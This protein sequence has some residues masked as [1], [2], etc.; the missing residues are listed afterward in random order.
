MSQ[1]DFVVP[2]RSEQRFTVLEAVSTNNQFG[3][4][5]IPQHPYMAPN[6]FGS[7]HQDSWCSES[8]SLAGPTSTQLSLTLQRNPYGYT[9]NMVTNSANQMIG[10]SLQYASRKFF[11]VMFDQE[12]NIISATEA[13]AKQG[14]TFGGGYFYLDNHDNTVTVQ[15]NKIASYPTQEQPLK[16]DIYPLTPNWTSV[17]IVELVTGDN[18]NTLYSALPVWTGKPNLYWCLIAGQYDYNNY[19][20][21]KLESPAYMAVVEILPDGNGGSVTSLLG[22]LELENQWN[23]N[24]FAVDEQ[25]AYIVTN[26]L[27]KSG[28]AGPSYLWAFAFDERSG[29]VSVRW[30]TEYE[31]AGYLKPG[32]KNIGSGTTPTLTKAEDGTD[33]VAITDNADPQLNVLVCRRDNGQPIAQVPCFEKMRSADEA[34]LIGVGSTFVAE[35]NFAHYPTWPHS[36]TIPNGTGMS[37]IEVNPDGSNTDLQS[38]WDMPDTHFYAMN[39]LCRESGIIFAHTCDWSG[40]ESSEKGG[41]YYISAIDSFNGRTIWRIPLGRGVDYC[42]EYGGIYFNHNGDLYIGTNKYIARISN[43]HDRAA[44]DE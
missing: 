2:E 35:N 39:M 25:G 11:V 19:P 15:E 41:M 31:N 30:K 9:P 4:Y 20:N 42:H 34:S 27:A 29:E 1:F 7:P 13:G 28:E 3:G 26:G 43:Y 22:K 40:A 24:T 17:N 16:E 38:T 6:N 10:V 32:Q 36:Q 14:D 8:V 5:D 44:G 37:L 33:L 23:N 21:A 12:C 18:N